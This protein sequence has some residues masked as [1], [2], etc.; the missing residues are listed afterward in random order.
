MEIYSNVG[1]FETPTITFDLNGGSLEII[2]RSIPENPIEFYHPLF[3]ALD[4]YEKLGKPGKQQIRRVPWI[5]TQKDADA[6]IILSA[7][8]IKDNIA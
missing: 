6:P 4:R 2:G 5:I 7:S 1:T 8:A 3:E